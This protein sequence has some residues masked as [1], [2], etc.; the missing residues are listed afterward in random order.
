VRQ[1]WLFAIWGVLLALIVY[2]ANTNVLP[3]HFDVRRVPGGDK[4]GH[5]FLLGVASLLAN[6]AL[7]VREWRLGKL[8]LLRG[9]VIVGTLITIEECTQIW[10]PNRTFSAS[11]MF[12]NFAGII[13]FGRIAR[14][15]LSRLPK[16]PPKA[17]TRPL[18]QQ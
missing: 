4:A 16:P 3:E 17:E 6:L 1:R 18:D 9:S 5:F 2:M 13:V 8:R 7:K 14:W 11:D 15:H 12:W 10:S